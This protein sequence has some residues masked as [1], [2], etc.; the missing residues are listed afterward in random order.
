MESIR[1]RALLSTMDAP[2]R[3]SMKKLLPNVTVPELTT[4][5]YPSAIL[6]IL[7]KEES[8]SLLGC[9]T[10][11]LLRSSVPDIHLDSL[12]TAV[13]KLY[14]ATPEH[15]A[16]IRKSKTTPPF[17]EAV[18]Q[19]REKI[20]KVVKGTLTFDTTVR[21]GQV[22]GHPDAQTDTQIFE[23]KMTGLLKKNWIEFLYQLFAYAALCEQAK[24]VY[25]VLP[26]QTEV[27]AFDLSAWP[28]DKRTKF[29]D[30]LNTTSI[31]RQ[32]IESV[33]MASLQT[34]QLSYNIGNHIQRGK[35]LAETIQQLASFASPF[36]IFLGSSLSSKIHISDDE[37]ARTSQCM[38]STRLFVH[39]PYI[40][41]LC[42]EPGE[43]N[44]YGT[45][46]LIKN[47]N[48]ASAI[49]CKGVVVHVGKSTDKELGKALANMRTNVLKAIEHATPSCPI[50]LETPAGQGTETLTTYDD[51]VSF[52][53]SFKDPRIAI[54]VDTCHV[55]A[56]GS[57]PLDYIRRLTSEK[58]ELLQ[59]VHFNDSAT[60]CGSC[61]DRHAYFGTG[62]I[63][64]KTM[65]D[66][67][68]HC[69]EQNY[70]MVIE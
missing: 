54:C 50:L 48:Y 13:K 59:L 56:S 22:E 69:K 46:L 36:Q 25:L 45:N 14:P 8:Y 29:R 53:D 38:S 49:G 4:L 66:I 63:G 37:L 33:P 28:T 23:V 47:L 64:L 12:C 5:R 15:E 20:E 18:R 9:I 30:L 62:K 19:T 70:P 34:I 31:N 39:S 51:F 17:L 6:S 27:W 68:D 40:I 26:L 10:E 42:S 24:E 1:V 16:K 43:K 44:D 52:V 32:T 57:Q 60:V 67:A 55:F 11:E 7:P 2:T 21:Y 61:V 65:V 41:N 3:A 35:N 58:K